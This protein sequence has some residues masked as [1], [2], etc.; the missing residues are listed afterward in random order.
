MKYAVVILDGAAG[1]PLKQFGEKTSLEHAHT[2]YLDLLAREGLSGLVHNVPEGMEPSSNVA[3][4][5]IMGYDPAEFPIGRGAI[6]GASCG[7][8]LAEDEVALRLNLVNIN[9]EGLMH[10]YS[11]GDLTTEQGNA[12]IEELKVLDDDTFTL[13][14]SVS[15]RGILVVK[16]HPELNCGTYYAAHNIS[17]TPI[18]DKWPSG[19]GTDFI[20]DYMKRANELLKT[21]KMNASREER[22]LLRATNTWIFW[23]GMRP[24]NMPSFNEKYGVNAGMLS[25][26]DLLNGLAKLTGVRRYSFDGITDAADNDY[27]AMGKGAIEML[28]NEDLVFIHVENP[29]TEGHN[30][31]AKEKVKSIEQVDECILRRLKEWADSHPDQQLRTLVLPDH[32]TPIKLKTHCNEPVP[33][34]LNGDGF[35][36]NEGERLTEAEAAKSNL[37]YMHGCELMS[38]LLR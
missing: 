14:P 15:F 9:D 31:D 8:E 30:G 32:P 27:N 4:T 22:G 24:N 33:F 5:S 2:P 29:D 38:M 13:Y 37:E 17:D 20:C 19:P 35:E 21:S 16:G 7:I 1:W 34:V 28:N 12:I 18:A 23:P 10:S 3:C 25:A 26:V 36:A 11:A 6:E